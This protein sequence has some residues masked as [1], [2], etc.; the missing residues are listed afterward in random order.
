MKDKKLQ[1]E[2]Q[3]KPTESISDHGACCGMELI[4]PGIHMAEKQFSFPRRYRYKI[5]SRLVVRLC[6]SFSS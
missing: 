4:Y 5:A 6:V 1:R 3:K 2:Y